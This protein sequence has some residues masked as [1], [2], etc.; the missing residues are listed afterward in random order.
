[1]KTHKFVILLAVL[2]LFVILG[3]PS[4]SDSGGGTTPTDPDTPTNPTTPTVEVKPATPVN[5]KA[6]F[7]DKKNA[8][9]ITWDNPEDNVTYEVFR[10]KD[11]SDKLLTN[12]AYAKSNFSDTS[13]PLETTISY[14]VRSYTTV[15]NQYSDFQ[16][17]T[18]IVVN[19]SDLRVK[20]PQAT[21]LAFN[22]KNRITWEAISNSDLNPLYEVYRYISKND[23]NPVKVD[24]PIQYGIDLIRYIDDTTATSETP[25]YYIIKWKDLN[26]NN[27]GLDSDYQFGIFV[28]L[29]NEQLS[30]PNDDFYQLP[31]NVTFPQMTDLFIF[32]DGDN[33]DVDCFKICEIPASADLEVV[34][35]IVSFDSLYNGKL[36]YEYIYESNKIS[37]TLINNENNYFLK[38]NFGTDITS[39]DLKNIYFR[40]IPED[41][42]KCTYSITYTNK[43]ILEN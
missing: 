4:P 24:L 35:V 14:K 39:T 29:V 41:D 23:Q 16:E 38:E 3:C 1:M 7:N 19:I 30:E 37:G 43:W 2:S 20:N 25:Y 22:N 15:D 27:Y 40:I 5:L 26:S 34:N 10:V 13:F 9:D 18:A 31:Y 17:S 8:I 42:I 11:S 21:I 6:E 36:K 33:K 12:Q 32:K 28:D